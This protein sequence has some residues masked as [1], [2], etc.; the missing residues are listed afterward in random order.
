MCGMHATAT[1]TTTTTQ[2]SRQADTDLILEQT[3]FNL[4]QGMC[5][6]MY[7]TCTQACNDIKQTVSKCACVYARVRAC[8]RT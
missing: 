6:S 4:E 1:T 3:S 8:A 5:Y 2:F 7:V